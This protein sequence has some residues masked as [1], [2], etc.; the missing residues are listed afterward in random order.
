MVLFEVNNNNILQ[1]AMKKR[2][3]GEMVRVYQVLVDRLKEKVIR[4]KINLL[5]NEC[6]QEFK[7]TI[8]GNDMKY[9]LVPSHNHRRNIAKKAFQ[10]LKTILWPSYAA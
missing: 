9:Q 8:K 10:V 5:D 4:P 1:A 7:D 2:T 6:S 3:S